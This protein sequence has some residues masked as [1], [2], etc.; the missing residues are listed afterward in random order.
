MFE[1]DFFEHDLSGKPEPTFP[2]HAQVRFIPRYLCVR[3]DD[4]PRRW[5]SGN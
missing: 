2:D 5:A 4:D 3:F 1:R